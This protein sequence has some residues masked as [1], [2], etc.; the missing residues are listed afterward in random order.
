MK[1]LRLSDL[2]KRS[3]R[4]FKK[5]GPIHYTPEISNDTLR[6]FVKKTFEA[7]PKKYQRYLK[8]EKERQIEKAVQLIISDGDSGRY[9]AYESL[10]EQAQDSY[11]SGHGGS[12]DVIYKIFRTMAPSVYSKYNSY[13]YRLGYS[14]SEYFKDNVDYV[15][16]KNTW[17]VTLDLPYKP[18]GV[19]Y[20]Q[21]Y[22]RIRWTGGAAVLLD[23]KML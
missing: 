15:S 7:L 21:I 4:W 20:N 22:I 16:D 23:A 1:S 6:Y 12:I 9:D 11:K 18:K 14:A 8:D 5:Y 10:I 17:E 3:N 19:I 13:V 2:A